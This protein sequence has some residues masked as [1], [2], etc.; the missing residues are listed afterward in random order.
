M[1]SQALSR[2]I[3]NSTHRLSAALSLL[4]MLSIASVAFPAWSASDPGVRLTLPDAGHP[5]DGL[6]DNQRM[7][8]DSGAEDFSELDDVEEGLGPR[9]NAEGCVSCHSQPAIGGSAPAVNP[10]VTLADSVNN[11]LPSFITHDGPIREARFVNNPD[12]SPDGGV[13]QLFVITGLPNTDGCEIVQPDFDAQLANN[14]VVFRI[15][16]PTFG[17]G[18]VEAIADRDILANASANSSVKS[19]LGI[20]GR[21]NHQRKGET[22]EPS[23]RT[24]HS[25]NDGTITR[26]GWKAQNKSL[27]IFSGEAYNAEQGI[28]NELFPNEIDDTPGCQFAT[29]PNDQTEFEADSPANT[30]GGPT[31]F[32]HFMRF[33]APPQPAPDDYLP[34]IV[35]GRELFTAIGCALCHTPSFNTGE[36]SVAALSEQAVNLYSDLLVHDIGPDLADGISQGN[37]NGNEFRTAPLWGLGQRVFFLH[38]G[39]TTDLVEAIQEH[40][41]GGRRRQPGSEANA[42]VDNYNAL[43]DTEQQQLLNFLRSL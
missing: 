20:R 38:D 34:G 41:S 6:T 13:H 2:K 40:K 1:S 10:L 29:T 39:R 21:V 11:I 14:N 3:A 15:P 19:R 36:N 16:T 30:A 28:T 24:N 18:L 8:F 43:S 42:V 23:G 25:G 5:I 32:T 31:R 27:M 4:G 12:G 9:F 26:F 7:F 35:E 33:L 22:I 37:A 17:L